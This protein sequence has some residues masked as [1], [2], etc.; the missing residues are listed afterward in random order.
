MSVSARILPVLALLV[1]LAI[2]AAPALAG[3]DALEAAARAVAAAR[4]EKD[5][6]ALA[7]ALY[8]LRDHDGAA[9]VRVLVALG[10]R[11]DA[12][13][14]V[15]E[16]ALDALRSFRSDAAAKELLEALDG[17]RG[18]RRL[19]LLEG[20][21]LLP[22]GDAV[23]PLVVA[24][25][26]KDPRER[27][28]AVAGLGARKDRTAAL[29]KALE[30]AA[31][32]PD[33]RVR[34]AALTGLGKG[35]VSGGLPLLHALLREEGRLFGDAWFALRRVSGQSLAPVAERWADWWRTLPGE[36]EFR[37]DAPPPEAPRPTVRMAGLVSW[38]KRVV[39]V[40][41]VSEGMRDEPGYDAAEIT[42]REVVEAGGDALEQWKAVRSR[43]DHAAATLRLALEGL[44]R[45][46][47]FDVVFGAESVN[48]LFRRLEPATPENVS[49][50][51]SRLRTLSG[52]GRQDLLGCLRQAMAAP[53][54][55]PLS[56]EARTEGADTVVYVG[57][58]LPTYGAETDPRRVATTFRRWNS[59]R[60]VVFLGVGVGNHGGDLLSDLAST[61]PRGAKSAIP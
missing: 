38:S 27:T 23:A 25:A 32:D 49:R 41:D 43:L 17:A 37:F 1:G 56:E 9:A 18:E 51:V 55:D 52:R 46:A 50:A 29:R 39:F 2:P 53:S 20:A 58:A 36:E 42:P 7:D 13:A 47:H 15:Q 35:D 30:E 31:R 60:Q 14:L 57:S 34:S 3:D 5:P 11:P 54:T 28:V 4:G 10:L 59:L 24:T 33:P 45:D 26:S 6:G 12:H 8:A 21:G 48:A 61:E 44:P 22:H 40:L 16:A 19:L